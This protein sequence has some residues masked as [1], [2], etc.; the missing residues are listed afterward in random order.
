MKNVGVPLHVHALL[1]TACAESAA[2]DRSPGRPSPVRITR[3]G[4]RHSW[5][6]GPST[7]Q[8]CALA[9]A[10]A[11]PVSRVADALAARSNAIELRP[12]R[13]TDLLGCHTALRGCRHSQ[14]LPSF[15]ADD[16][17]WARRNRLHRADSRGDSGDHPRAALTCAR[18]RC[19]HRD[20]PKPATTPTRRP[21]RVRLDLFNETQPDVV[22]CVARGLHASAHPGPAEIP[23]PEGRTV[24]L[25]RR[26]RK[27]RSTV[28]S[29][30]S[31]WSMY[32]RN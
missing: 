10:R 9:T 3:S 12:E 21:G 7:R 17:G 25:T 20:F 13:P 18:T 22:L 8:T 6:S 15:T 24:P 11:S 32:R 19:R 5:R 26:H 29:R 23:V 16:P 30:N 14:R 31:G 4:R 28:R 1:A 27:M 2:R